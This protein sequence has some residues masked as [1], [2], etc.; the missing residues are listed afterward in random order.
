MKTVGKPASAP[1]LFNNWIWGAG[2]S[3]GAGHLGVLKRA[4]TCKVTLQQDNHLGVSVGALIAAFISNGYTSE[5][6][7]PIFIEILR[8]RRNPMN[9][10]KAF[11]LADPVTILLGG[12]FHLQPYMKEIVEKYNLKP[13]K[14]LRILACDQR[15]EPVLFQGEDYDLAFA[16]AASGSVPGAFQPEWELR[17]GLPRMLVDGALYH[18]NPTEFNEGPCIVSKFRPATE[19]PKEWET[20]A[21]LYFHLREVFFPLAGNSRYVDTTK[22]IVIESGLPHVAGLNLGIKDET[23]HAMVQNGFDSAA[24]LEKAIADG[25]V[26]VEK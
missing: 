5:Q 2:G 11:R 17:F 18:Y 21:D 19:L 6:L 1:P 23:I 26:A 16:L 13:N 7:V 22:H 8:S 25:R 24:V 14:R 3:H 10:M 4:E 20:F 12:F 15:H 9:W